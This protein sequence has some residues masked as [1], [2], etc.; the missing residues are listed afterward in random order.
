VINFTDDPVGAMASS[1]G[2]PRI[3]GRTPGR[4]AGSLGAAFFYMRRFAEV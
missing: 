1:A 2:L 3:S 4:H